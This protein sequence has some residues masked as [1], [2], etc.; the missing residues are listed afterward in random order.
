MTFL[1][2]TVTLASGTGAVAWTTL[3]VSQYVGASASAVY[4]LVHGDAGGNTVDLDV[5]LRKDSASPEYHVL[6]GIPCQSVADAWADN[7]PFWCPVNR[8]KFDYKT[9]VVINPNWSITLIAWM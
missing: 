5:Y 3:D 8:G 2:K 1:D 4:V 6:D 7:V 9:T